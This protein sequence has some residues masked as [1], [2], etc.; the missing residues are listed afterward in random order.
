[1]G[2]SGF[3]GWTNWQIRPGLVKLIELVQ[4]PSL[5]KWAQ[6]QPRTLM[7][8]AFMMPPLYGILSLS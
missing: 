6:A 1:M 7:R 2:S 8:L 5:K 3:N 4:G